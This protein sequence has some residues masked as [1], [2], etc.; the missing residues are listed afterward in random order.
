MDEA[1]VEDAQDRVD[2]QSPPGSAAAGARPRPGSSWPRPRTRRGWW[3]AGAGAHRRVDRRG[4]AERL[5]PGARLN[6]TVVATNRPWWLT[7]TGGVAGLEAGEGRERDHRLLRARHRRARGGA[8]LAR[9]DGVGEPRCGRNRSRWRRPWS[10]ASVAV[11]SRA[12]AGRAGAAGVGPRSPPPCRPPRSWSPS[13]GL[14]A[15]G[16]SIDLLSVSGVWR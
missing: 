3:R 16:A 10:R 6:E 1:L 9:R 11:V 13:P 7:C 12:A 4:G 5:L 15:R 8:A 2:G 14:A